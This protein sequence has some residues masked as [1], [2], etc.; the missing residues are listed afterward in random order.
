MEVAR[1]LLVDI[2]PLSAR[3]LRSRVVRETSPL[4]FLARV[5]RAGRGDFSINQHRKSHR[6]HRSVGQAILRPSASI[7][8]H[9]RL[10]G[11][12]Q[13]QFASGIRES[14]HLSVGK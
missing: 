3:M 14:R 12:L 6:D 4:A 7:M 9:S 5:P 2:P 10:P 8:L 11:R 1:D 13:E